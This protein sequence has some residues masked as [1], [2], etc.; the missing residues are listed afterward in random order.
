MLGAVW[1]WYGMVWYWGG[2]VLVLKLS[3]PPCRSRVRHGLGMPVV[4]LMNTRPNPPT[5]RHHELLIRRCLSKHS[6]R[7]RPGAWDCTWSEPWSKWSP[8]QSS[9]PSGLSGPSGPQDDQLV[10]VVLRTIMQSISRSA[11]P[12][13]QRCVWSEPS[14]KVNCWNSCS[15]GKS[16]KNLLRS[17]FCVALISESMPL[18]YENVGIYCSCC[19]TCFIP[20]WNSW[21][22]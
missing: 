16:T 14:F 22:R 10:Q 4:Q 5:V 6:P 2:M 8:G 12:G 19:T 21:G 3:G 17:C 7:S 11:R 15:R 9:G 18:F 20:E 1:C 13:I